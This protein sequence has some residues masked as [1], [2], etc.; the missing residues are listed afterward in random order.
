QDDL[1]VSY[2][3]SYGAQKATYIPEVLDSYQYA[4]MYRTSELNS[5]IEEENLRF[6]LEDIQKYKDGTNP[7]LYP[8]TNWFD[9]ILEPS[10]MFTKH[11]LQLSGGAE[12]VQYLF[13]LGYQR[14]E[15]LTPGQATDRYNFL[16]KT[17]ADL[18]SWLT[19]STNV[20]FIYK[21]YN[22]SK[23]GVSLVEFL[24]VPPTQ[25]ACHTNGDWGSIRD[26][27]QATTEEINYNQLRNLEEKGRGNSQTKH[28]LGNIMAELRPFEG[29]KF[30]NQM[31]YRYYDYKSFSFQNTMKGVPS[32]LNPSEGVISGTESD[33]NQM[34][35]YWNYSEKLIYDGWI[36]Y[37]KTFSEIHTIGVMAG[38]HADSWKQKNIDVGRKMFPS[39]DMNAISGGSTDP[40]NQLTTEGVFKEETS[41]S[42]FGRVTYNYNERYLFEA[43]FRADASS[44]FA[45]V[46]KWGYFPSFSAGWR[47]SEE[48]FMS[49]LAWIDNL[50]LRASWGKNGNI[51]NV[52]L[53]DTYDTFS[54]AGTI[55][56][57]GMVR[58]I[59]VEGRIANPNL[60][61]EKTTTTDIGMDLLINRGIFGVTFDYYRRITD[62]ILVEQTDV[63]AER[64]IS[65][66]PY[67]NVGQVENNGV[68][69]ALTHS[70]EIGDFSYDLGVNLSVMN[71]EITDL[72]ENIKKLPPSNYWV[73]QI[74]FPIGS[75]Y[76]Y[77]AD[78]LYSTEDIENGNVVP[79]GGYEI[80]AGMVKLV[81]QNG[82]GKITGDDRTIA[83]SDVPDFTY[84]LNLNLSYKGFDLS[85]FGQGIS[86]V[87]VYMDNEASQAFFNSAVPREW[88]LDNWTPENQNARYPKLFKENDL[89]FQYNSI[90][91]SYWLFDADYFRVKNI[92]LGYTIPE[93]TVKSIGLEK[94]RV[95]VS[96]DNMFT[97]RGDRRM[98]DFDP[99]RASGRGAQ[100][101][102]KTYT[103]GVSVTF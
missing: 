71:N 72:G 43:N 85:A 99:E 15:S 90:Q 75:F 57:G 69:L 28:L 39:N 101:N 87:K 33:V 53:Y 8:N 86:G 91:S 41:L 29:F 96:G 25:V 47:V 49:D 5:G 50:K 46:G 12:K 92:T 52:G 13:G 102:M 84:G 10:A 94:V 81:D 19:V 4:E 64:G 51:R 2:N 7:D 55:Y 22:R 82:D 24:R 32:F 77:E 68:E 70:N 37:D 67:K 78:G 9:L 35:N 95:Y 40:D 83:G 97:L 23:G 20:N 3:G 21:N 48:G 61:W 80:E 73:N 27:R 42:Y 74:G 11:S 36:N 62:D 34:D 79:F 6:S 1:R 30:T 31:G 98:E 14:D 38:M 89:R 16:S 17:T 60:T 58:P 63:L 44:R 45:N 26:F 59:L 65:N 66:L 56:N 103:A 93:A 88:Q 100:L 54:G 76:M 18:K